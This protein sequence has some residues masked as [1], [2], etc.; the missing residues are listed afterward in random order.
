VREDDFGW[1]TELLLARQKLEDQGTAL[2]PST[3]ELLRKIVR[4]ACDGLIDHERRLKKIEKQLK[5]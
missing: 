3:I 4:H 1:E 2:K 5:S